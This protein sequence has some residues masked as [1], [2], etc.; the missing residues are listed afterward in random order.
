MSIVP[1]Q[2]CHC[3]LQLVPGPYIMYAYMRIVGPT[4]IRCW[5]AEYPDAQAALATWLRIAKSADWNSISAVRNDFPH[6][7]AVKVRSENVV[8]VF[9]ICGNRY[10]LIVAIK[11][12]FRIVYALRF[13]THADYDES[14]W[15]QQL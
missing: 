13:L 14:Q 6:A 5:A 8:T 9:N 1:R 12:S 7:D 11:Y 3:G 10:R 2:R 4:Q 15:K